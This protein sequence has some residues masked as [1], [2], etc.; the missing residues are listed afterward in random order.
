MKKVLNSRYIKKNVF[1]LETNLL[2]E[3]DLC[4]FN[5]MKHT[6]FV[7]QNQGRIFL[8]KSIHCTLKE[9]FHVMDYYA[10]SAIWEVK[11]MLSSQK[12]LNDRY[13]KDTKELLK[14][15]R[16]KLKQKETTLCKYRKAKGRL[17]IWSKNPVFRKD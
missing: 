9:Q 15:V 17:R 1:P 14:E 5:S 16:K 11:A 4:I 7:W 2:I 10:G 12:E 8:N 6:A 13:L 3:Q